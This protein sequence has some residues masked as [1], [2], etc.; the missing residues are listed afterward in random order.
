LSKK[1]FL[2]YA[3]L[4]AMSSAPAQPFINEIKAF[5]KQDS[6][7]KPPEGAILLIGSS[8]FTKWKDVGDYFPD[9]TIVNR[10]FGGSSLPHLIDYAE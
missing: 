7:A 10:A 2:L 5:A 8:S 3:V 9:K 6:M 4:F 1:L